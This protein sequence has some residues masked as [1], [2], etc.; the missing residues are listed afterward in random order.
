M[1]RGGLSFPELRDAREAVARELI[2]VSARTDAVE[3]LGVGERQADQVR[4]NTALDEAPAVPAAELYTGVLYDALDLP[5]LTPLQRKRAEGAIVVVTALYGAVRLSDEIAPYRLSMGVKLPGTGRLAAFWRPHLD[6]ALTA[7]AGARLVVDC[8]SSDYVAAWRP[9]RLG[10]QW[11]QIAV[12]G[13]SHYAK[14]TRGLVARA[15]CQGEPAATPEELAERLA[16]RFDVSLTAPQRRSSAWQLDV[17]AAAG[18]LS[19][20]Q[21]RVGRP[22]ERR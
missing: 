4:A 10:H 1:A 17:T 12:P 20:G 6:D 15:L 16:V 2:D 19:G 7:A 18:A 5:S 8:R 14:H 21:G 3:I 22:E 9:R 13:A 11:G